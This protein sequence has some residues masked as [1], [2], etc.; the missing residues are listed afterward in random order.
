MGSSHYLSKLTEKDA[1][2]IR[3]HAKW[4]IEQDPD[5]ALEV[6]VGSENRLTPSLV[7]PIL[8]EHAPQFSAVSKAFF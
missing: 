5:A 8:H 3:K 1:N 6:L 2:V 7:L 4:V